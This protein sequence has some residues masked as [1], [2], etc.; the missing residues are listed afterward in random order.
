MALATSTSQPV[1]RLSASSAAVTSPGGRPGVAADDHGV[2]DEDEE[3]TARTAISVVNSS[4]K[5]PPGV[6]RFQ[7]KRSC[8]WKRRPRATSQRVARVLLHPA[9]RRARGSPR[10]AGSGS[11]DDDADDDDDQR[12][13]ERRRRCRRTWRRCRCCARRRSRSRM[14]GAGPEPGAEDAVGDERAVAHPRAAGDERREGA[15]EADEAADEDR[16]AAVAVEVVL[17]LLEALVADP[18]PGAVAE[19]ELAAEAAADEEAGRVA[20][21]RPQNQ[22]IAISR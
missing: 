18:E 17:D 14:C 2:G 15:D 12:A 22:A 6:T 11:S 21:R 19:Q 10:P 9:H 16:L 7:R 8:G 20:R 3:A 5:V 1:R 4:P 13:E